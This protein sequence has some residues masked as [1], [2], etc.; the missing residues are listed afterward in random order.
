VIVN[1]GRLALFPAGSIINE[2]VLFAKGIIKRRGDGVK[3]LGKGS[4]ESALD[5]RIASVSK[6]AREKIVAAG[7]SWAAEL[8]SG[9]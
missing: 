7:G 3:L 8:V 5:I 1:L 9:K 4:L 6:S 2:D